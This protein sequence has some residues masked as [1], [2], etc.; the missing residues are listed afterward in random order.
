MKQYSIRF[1][2]TEEQIRQATR[3]V[4]HVFRQC[5]NVYGGKRIYSKKGYCRM[6][7]EAYWKDSGLCAYSWVDVYGLA[8]E[9]LL[10]LGYEVSCATL[11][12]KICCVWG[13]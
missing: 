3:I 10:K 11:G 8:T 1:Y 12:A 5:Y 6:I 4:D 7:Y 9:K 2:G 13:K